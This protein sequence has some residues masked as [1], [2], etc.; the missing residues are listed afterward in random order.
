MLFSCQQL[1]LFFC[2]RNIKTLGA[3]SPFLEGVDFF[4]I[5]K[6][7]GVVLGDDRR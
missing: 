6:K 7:D 5:A 1:F 4:A 3:N 2:E